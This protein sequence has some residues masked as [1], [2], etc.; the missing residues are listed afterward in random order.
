VQKGAAIACSRLTTVMPSSGRACLGGV[1]CVILVELNDVAGPR[2]CNTASD[3]RT[4]GLHVRPEARCERTTAPD[5]ACLAAVDIWLNRRILD[6]STT[7]EEG[8]IRPAISRLNPFKSKQG[9]P[10]TTS[11]IIVQEVSTFH[12]L[13]VNTRSR[14]LHPSLYPDWRSPSVT[15]I[16][17]SN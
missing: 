4:V 11:H 7:A 5:S 8:A 17:R 13:K 16:L 10:S 6:N 1:C 12:F 2:E 14:L 3:D 15:R 9:R